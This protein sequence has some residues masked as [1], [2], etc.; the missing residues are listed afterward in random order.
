MSFYSHSKN[1]NVIV[2]VI[3]I[4]IVLNRLLPPTRPTLAP[5]PE[6][7]PRTDSLANSLYLPL[8][9]SWKLQRNLGY[10]WQSKKNKHKPHTQAGT[11]CVFG[12]R[13]ACCDFEC[14]RSPL[15]RSSG[16]PR[17]WPDVL[18]GWL[19]GGHNIQLFTLLDV[20]VSSL[21][22]GN[23]N[24]LCIVPTLTDDPRRESGWQAEYSM[25]SVYAMAQLA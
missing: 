20:C 4:M 5:S 8:P 15:P 13:K 9:P 14:Q 17:S 7:A 25:T 21:R 22:R 6:R 2:I 24:L 18:A 1:N 11:C 23:A 3:V 12:T 19:D 10:H 16:A